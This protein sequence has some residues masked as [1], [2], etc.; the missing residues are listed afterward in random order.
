MKTAAWSCKDYIQATAKS[1][2][3]EGT[4]LRAALLSASSIQQRHHTDWQSSPHHT[5]KARIRLYDETSNAT[6][7]TLIDRNCKITL[8]TLL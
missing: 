1:L 8:F 7:L 5:C 6:T 3:H 4:S 2:S